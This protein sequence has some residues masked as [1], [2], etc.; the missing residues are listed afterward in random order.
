MFTHS[1]TPSQGESLGPLADPIRKRSRKPK[2]PGVFERLAQVTGG[3]G[4]GQLTWVV[5]DQGSGFAV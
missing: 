4:S 3:V 1:L 2:L 5:L